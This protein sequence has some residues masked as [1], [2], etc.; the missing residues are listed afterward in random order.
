M[1]SSL[2][3][4]LGQGT[5]GQVAI[6]DITTF[7][8]APISRC[9]DLS[10]SIDLHLDSMKH[11]RERAVGGVVSGLIGIG[12]EVTWE[13]R[14]FGLTL[15]MTSRITAFEPPSYFQDTMIS[16]PFAHFQHD[17]RF[18]AVADGTRVQDQ[19]RFASPLG[20][21]GRLADHLAITRYLRRLLERRAA[22]IK[23][24]AES[25]KPAG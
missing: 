15:R 2:V 23:Q 9:F 4:A 3:R 18:T 17:H 21:L 19:V 25:L 6:I 20:P 13:A 5:G 1:I 24:T 16:G 14:H 12:E 7:I 22:I 10:R 11:T 8:A